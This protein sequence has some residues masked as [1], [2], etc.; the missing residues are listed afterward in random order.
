V[1]NTVLEIKQYQ[2]EWLQHVK[3]IDTDRIPKHALKYGP[4][5]RKRERSVGRPRKR[6]LKQRRC[7]KHFTAHDDDCTLQPYCV[8]SAVVQCG[9]A[10]SRCSKVTWHSRELHLPKA[11]VEF[12]ITIY[13]SWFLGV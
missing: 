1:Q 10:A 2:R 3:R 9:V 5:E 4:K 12:G 7:A 6:G 11:R 13:S 8:L